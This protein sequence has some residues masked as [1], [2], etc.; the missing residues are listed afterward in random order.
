MHHDYGY[1]TDFHTTQFIKKEV[2]QDVF[3]LA[4]SAELLKDNGDAYY[5]TIN[6]L[7]KSLIKMIE[8]GK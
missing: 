5:R 3:Q 6:L 1:T 2:K 8:N 7:G 4:I